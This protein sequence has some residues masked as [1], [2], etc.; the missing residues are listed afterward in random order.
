MAPDRFVSDDVL[1]RYKSLSL[2]GFCPQ[3]VIFVHVPTFKPVMNLINNVGWI[4]TV[5]DVLA[6]T[7]ILV[8]EFL[9]N[10]SE[11]NSTVRI[12]DEVFQITVGTKIRIVD[13]C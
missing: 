10:F 9:E 4:A 7:S 2:R 5:T 1:I 12:R 3:Q 11:L 6:F 8:R 13:F